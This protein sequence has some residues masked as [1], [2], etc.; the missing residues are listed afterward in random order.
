MRPFTR[1]IWYGA[2]ETERAR[3]LR[4]LRP[5]WDIHRHRIAPR[6]AEQLECLVRQGRFKVSA[7]KVK[8]ATLGGKNLSIFWRPRGQD[9]LSC[10][11]AQRVINCTGPLGDLTR[12]RDPLLQRLIGRGLIRAD[13]LSIGIDVDR[14]GRALTRL[15]TA[16]NKLFVVGPMTRGAHW[17]IIAVPDIRVQVWSLARYLT[18]THW[19]EGAGL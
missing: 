19:V 13:A 1:D 6:V 16:N 2:S 11:Q 7:G 14:Q 10:I 8:S 18:A 17:E 15:G 5:Y 9:G 3:F 12:T 4:H